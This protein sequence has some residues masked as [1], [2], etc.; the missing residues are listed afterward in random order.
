MPKGTKKMKRQN[1]LI[2]SLVVFHFLVYHIN[3]IYTGEIEQHIQ[4]LIVIA[5][6]LLIYFLSQELGRALIGAFLAFLIAAM[7][8]NIVDTGSGIKYAVFALFSTVIFSRYFNVINH[9]KA[10]WSRNK[11]SKS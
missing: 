5:Y 9:L 1:F 6:A 10:I 11:S 3:L 8:E 7:A 2:F 4:D